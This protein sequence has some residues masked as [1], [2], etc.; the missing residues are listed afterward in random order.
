MPATCSMNN[1]DHLCPPAQMETVAV[2]GFM[3]MFAHDAHTKLHVCM[4][5]YIFTSVYLYYAMCK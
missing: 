4:C 2:G 1:G 3:G 5:T